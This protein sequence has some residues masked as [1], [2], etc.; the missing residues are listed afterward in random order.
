M[1]VVTLPTFQRCLEDGLDATEREPGSGFL[2]GRG[3][4]DDHLE[5]YHDLQA[6]PARLGGQVDWE[7]EDP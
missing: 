3:T 7:L 4:R 1:Y 2:T 6:R 5:T